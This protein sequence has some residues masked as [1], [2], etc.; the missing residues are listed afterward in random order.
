MAVDH[1]RSSALTAAHV[2]AEKA[3][4]AAFIAFLNPIFIS[5]RNMAIVLGTY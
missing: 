3:K 2:T 4:D 5:H 1:A